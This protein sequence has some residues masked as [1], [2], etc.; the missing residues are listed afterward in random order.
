VA[1]WGALHIAT[2][3]LLASTALAQAAV[4]DMWSRVT[5]YR[6]QWGVP[7][8]YAQDA[9]ALAF[10]FAYAQAE[11]H[12]DP[13][14]LAFRM[15]NGRAAEVLGE[16]YA[17]S[18]ELALRMQHGALAYDAF[19]A[20]DDATRAL[21]AGF[22]EGIHA[23][24][25]DNPD[26]TPKWAEGIRPS[27]VLAL[28]HYFLLSQA[29]F[30]LDD[31]YYPARA[32]PSGNLWAVGPGR[33]KSGKPIL[34]MNPHA[35]YT[36]PFQW[37]EAH[38]SAPG[39]EV[40]GA[41][42]YGLPVLLMGH[43]AFMAWGL[44]PN[45]PDTADIYVE[46]EYAVRRDPNSV[47]TQV[48]DTRPIVSSHAKSF[49]VWN[50]Q[51]LEQRATWIERTAR[52]P[53]VAYG[54]GTPFSMALG[55]YGAFGTVRQFYDMGRAR[56]L[57]EFR[58]ALAQHQLPTFH[59]VYADRG[60]SLFY[61]Y[62]AIVGE[63][64]EATYA[65]DALA[66]ATFAEQLLTPWDKPLPNNEPIYGWGRGITYASLPELVNPNAGFVQ[67]SGTPPWLAT[68]GLREFQG[69]WP[70]WLVRDADSYRAKRLRSLLAQEP[71]DLSEHQAILFD[72]VVPVA[73]FAVPFLLD[74]ADTLPTR[75]AQ[76]H[77]DYRAFID[78]LRDWDYLADV[79]SYGMTCFHVWW[80]L[81][82]RDRDGVVLPD[83][84]IHALMEEGP[85]W[86]RWRALE[87][88][89]QAAMMMRNAF[90]TV[91]VPWG[92]AHALVRGDKRLPL[93][94]ATS[95]DPIFT[96]GDM[97]FDGYGWPATQGFGFAMA[98]ELDDS[99]RAY[100][101]VPFGSSER[102]GS[103]HYDDQMELL[104]DRRMKR[105]YWVRR[106]VERY[107]QTAVGTHAVLRVPENDARVWFRGN[108]PMVAE[109]RSATSGLSLPN[110]FVAYS[111]FVE[112]DVSGRVSLGLDLEFGISPE[113]CTDAALR[114]L[115]VYRY[116]PRTGWEGV[117][118]QSWARDRR[119]L[120]ARDYRPGVFAV[121]GPPDGRRRDVDNAAPLEVDQ[122][123]TPLT[124]RGPNETDLRMAGV[125]SATVSPA[126]SSEN[127]RALLDEDLQ[128]V[129]SSPRPVEEPGDLEEPRVYYPAGGD[130]STA[131]GRNRGGVIIPN[132]PPGWDAESILESRRA[133]VA[134]NLPPP[135]PPARPSAV[136]IRGSRTSD[137]PSP[138]A[139]SPATDSGVVTPPSESPE[140]ELRAEAA[141][142]RETPAPP[143]PEERLDEIRTTARALQG[144]Q[145]STVLFSDLT[146]RDLKDSTP[147]MD[148]ETFALTDNPA[149]ASP[150]LHGTR[151]ELRPPAPGMLFRL[152]MRT[153]VMAQAT[154]RDLP[155]E[156]FP[157]GLTN[158]TP[159]VEIAHNPPQVTG[160]TA[161]TLQIPQGV[162]APEH[163][164]SLRIY[165]HDRL[166]GWEPLNRHNPASA[167]GQITGI[168]M[169]VRTYAVLGPAEHRLHTP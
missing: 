131:F 10:G 30:D 84:S 113:V 95:G 34:V 81:I 159:I 96:T 149:M 51:R 49:Y 94:G 46:S 62:A 137:T 155:A 52:G 100:T 54:L 13:M 53:V 140:A 63:K 29:P 8:V 93:G 138:S 139:E 41:T 56:N 127:S 91:S 5:V 67:A 37:Y 129:A 71:R 107:A 48:P 15:A 35:D 99:P 43:N 97:I 42:V 26:R 85:E 27:D 161:L 134:E 6:D 33:S 4:D 39:Y 150:L 148:R 153:P 77:P 104:A 17:E 14:L 114:G 102:R 18:D 142:L 124:F 32:V 160:T 167:D 72:R 9:H 31:A 69:S 88:A 87:T 36:G 74:S 116:D 11:D 64:R 115:A 132:V 86:F 111:R 3:C 169:G 154:V 60:G 136:P 73:A 163:L 143:E 133:M 12:L 44:A 146:P 25:A 108:A 125:E 57:G 168:D 117:T 82:R 55:G 76:F 45:E 112:T 130:D 50:G 119:V 1:R 158:Y 101:L 147:S 22:S 126:P 16:G 162:V 92:E 122:S 151:I 38:L 166:N 59:V 98:V 61:R 118:E 135:P 109:L 23:W 79:N 145:G 21:C 103:R 40:Y 66:N 128:R 65:P 58:R 83:E 70:G 110:G 164:P 19:A 105:A 106:D 144:R 78:T 165:T 156:P 121:L 90:Q 20:A 141:P 24:M 89:S 123:E 28:M 80:Q 157:D 75:N 7:H 68:T 120:Q 47:M 152:N 2:W